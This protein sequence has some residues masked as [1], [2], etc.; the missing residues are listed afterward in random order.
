MSEPDYLESCDICGK[1]FR[2][3]THYRIHIQKNNCGSPPPS[4]L[5][6]PGA[7]GG[8]GAAGAPVLMKLEKP[9]ALFNSGTIKRKRH[10]G[11]VESTGADAAPVLGSVFGPDTWETYMEK[12]ES[13]QIKAKKDV[14][15][16]RLVQ[17]CE[18]FRLEHD[19][20]KRRGIRLLHAIEQVDKHL[21][22]IDAELRI[23]ARYP[24]NHVKKRDI[25][26][27]H[28][29]Y[30]LE[31]LQIE[32]ELMRIRDRIVE[33]RTIVSNIYR[34]YEIRPDPSDEILRYHHGG[35]RKYGSKSRMS[36]MS[37]KSRKSR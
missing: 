26:Q 1:A 17:V 15:E 30:M 28:D 29:M 36:R 12:K 8:P 3:E 18:P 16:K 6:V 11:V 21:S 20:I 24:S 37:R 13:A 5:S 31:R 2:R 35:S 14:N 25:A 19:I 22:D 27:L 32:E 9:K 23:F 4:P 34:Q 33:I 10:S 7:A